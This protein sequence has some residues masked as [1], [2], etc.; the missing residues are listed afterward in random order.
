LKSKAAQRS[1][2]LVTAAL[3]SVLFPLHFAVIPHTVCE[4][5]G[6]IAK[7]GEAHEGHHGPEEPEPAN[8]DEHCPAAALFASPGLIDGAAPALL[9]EQPEARVIALPEEAKRTHRS[10]GVLSVSPC[11]SPPRVS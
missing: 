11:H 1:V 6:E 3:F 8:E 9:E 5:H 2:A 7:G 4:A 10:Y